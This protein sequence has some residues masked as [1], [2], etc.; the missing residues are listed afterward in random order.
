[1]KTI[2]RIVTAGVATLALGGMA[3]TTAATTASA[4]TTAP[5]AAAKHLPVLYGS[6][7]GRWH[8]NGVRPRG[9]ALGA[10]WTVNKMSWFRWNGSSAYG[11]GK[12]VAGGYDPKP[13]TDR[14]WVRITLTDVKYHNGR[15]YYAKMKMVGRPPHGAGISGV[16]HLVMRDGVMYYG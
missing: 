4:S 6:M 10:L 16:Q 11:S 8:S 9:I 2:Q 12:E 1:M 15:P 7:G 14:W 13:F 3:A 5:T